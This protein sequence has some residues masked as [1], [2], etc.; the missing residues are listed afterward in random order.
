M[1]NKATRPYQNQAHYEFY[2]NLEEGWKS[3]FLVMATGSGKTFTAVEIVKEFL[4]AAKRGMWIAHRTELIDQAWQTMYDHQIY[5]GIIMADKK[6]NY[7][8]PIQCCSIQTISKRKDLPPADFIIIDEA[9]HVSEKSQYAKIVALYPD[10]IILMLSATPYRLSGEGFANVFPDRPTKPIIAATMSSLIKSGWLCPFDY[11]IS[12]IPDMS[13]VEIT[14]T[15]DYEEN[16]ARKAMEMAPLVESYFKHAEGK[17]GIVFAINVAHS[18]EICSKYEN[19]GVKVEHLDGKTSKHDRNR[20]FTAFKKN[21]LKVLVNCGITTE[22][23]DLP[24]CEFVQHARP[25]KS[26]SLSSQ[27]SGRVSRALPGIVDLYD[28]AEERRYAIACSAKPYGIILDNAGIAFEHLMPDHNHDLMLYFEG[29][30]K[31]GRKAKAPTEIEEQLEMWVY[32]AEDETGK[33]F[34]FNRMKEVEG[35]KLIRVDKEA[36]RKI[37]NIKAIKEFDATYAKFKNV[38]TVKKPGYTAYRKYIEYC[39]QTQTFIPPE[40]WDYLTLKLVTENKAEYQK[41]VDHNKKYPGTIPEHVIKKQQDKI[42]AKGCSEDFMLKERR[43]YAKENAS[44]MAEYICQKLNL[45]I[46]K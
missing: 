46:Q 1:L 19:Q 9:H 38:A 20:I 6:T 30:K 27:M 2:K 43:K 28:T 16:Q 31:K 44:Q 32:V 42:E 45:T 3:Q 21:E 24:N 40:V 4:F 23:T 39:N 22:G 14:S 41:L 33:Q 5:A 11:Y 13:N 12:S 10:A 37:I 8:L 26:W 36:R 29:I 17:S 15:G 18:M 35:M 7:D 34:R 25:T